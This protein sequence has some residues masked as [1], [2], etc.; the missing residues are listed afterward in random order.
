MSPLLTGLFLFAAAPQDQADTVY[1]PWSELDQE[2]ALWDRSSEEEIAPATVSGYIQTSFLHSILDGS[3]GYGGFLVDTARLALSGDSAD[4]FSYRVSGDFAGQS[5][6]T[7]TDDD[8]D[9]DTEDTVEFD[10][11]F[12]SFEIRDAYIRSPMPGPFNLTIGNFKAPVLRSGRIDADKMLFA[13]RTHAAEALSER[14]LGVMIDGRWDILRGYL[15]ISNG[16]DRSDE[17][18]MI[19]TRL[20]VDVAGKG[21][22]LVEGALGA[23]SELAI[24]IGA[25]IFEDETVEEDGRIIGADLALT[26]DRLSISAEVVDFG[27]G[28]ATD[29]GARMSDPRGMRKTLTDTR[30]RS[31]MISYMAQPDKWEMIWRIDYL[32]EG[33]DSNRNI[34]T[35]GLNHYVE[36]H[37]LKWQVGVII[38]EFD[39]E[40]ET[41][42]TGGLFASF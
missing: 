6:S 36:G 31:F 42:L 16:E 7:L 37:D 38:D 18:M 30:P 20:E 9:P 26:Y 35:L 5:S 39:G 15:S 34:Q 4:G 22:S 29:Y 10:N 12:G 33:G 13:T 8:G 11:G 25:S 1:D 28:F 21:V 2:L 40:D 24:T 14:D 3:G 19:G 27:D 32:D 23:P 17:K 41:L